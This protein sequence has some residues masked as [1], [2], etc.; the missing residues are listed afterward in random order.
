[1]TREQYDPRRSD[2]GCDKTASPAP[3]R[4]L[5]EDR[6]NEVCGPAEYYVFPGSKTTVCCLTLRNGFQVVGSSACVDPR[7]FNE[8]VGRDLSYQAAR[9]QV[10]LLEAYLLQ[11]RRWGGGL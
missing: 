3:P 10:G 9:N 4:H 6:I 7:N 2:E 11:E 8:A 1:M 5:G